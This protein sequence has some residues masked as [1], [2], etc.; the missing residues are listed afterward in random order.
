MNQN[1]HRPPHTHTHTHKC[2]CVLTCSSETS[3]N[4]ITATDALLAFHKVSYDKK[5]SLPLLSPA[6]F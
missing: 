4:F 1:T 6:H 3:L 2:V 5:P